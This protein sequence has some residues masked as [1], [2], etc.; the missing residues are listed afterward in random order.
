MST[1]D[2]SS[3]SPEDLP[4]IEKQAIAHLKQGNI[5][6]LHDLVKIH[7]ARAVQT[8]AL[9]VSDRSTAEEIVQEAFIKAY[10][11]ID[12]FDPNRPFGPWFYRM[13]INLSLKM[14]R[15]QKRE[16]S[17][18]EMENVVAFK[19]C[20]ISKDIEPESWVEIKLNSEMVWQALN[21]LSANQRAAVVRR[22][23]LGENENQIEQEMKRPLTSI[24]WWLHSA[25]KKLSVLL[26]PIRDS[27]PGQEVDDEE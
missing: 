23:F 2:S 3:F 26:Q 9:M 24:K 1:N 20:L 17:L 13:V 11:K 6:G 12:Q 21:L 5:N 7:Q 27:T 4:E 25:R 14:I 10:E 16:H 15:K 8:A 18:E 19:E 22:Y